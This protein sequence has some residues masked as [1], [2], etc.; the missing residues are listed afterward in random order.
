MEAILTP[1]EYSEFCQKASIL[2]SKNYDLTY[3]VEKQP[4][5]NYKI[6]IAGQHNI[7][8]LDRLTD[9]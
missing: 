9:V 3:T 6:Q 1:N 5:G 4:D 2:E 8:E 7:E